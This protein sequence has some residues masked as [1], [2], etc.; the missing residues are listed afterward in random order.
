MAPTAT[1]TQGEVDNFVPGAT[2]FVLLIKATETKTTAYS[3][4]VVATMEDGTTKTITG[5]VNRADDNT[6][7]TVTSVS[8]GVDPV[9]VCTT[10][11]EL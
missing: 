11:S 7:Y 5:K 1:A 3:Y 4:S 8:L 2:P 10:I 9:T 6:G